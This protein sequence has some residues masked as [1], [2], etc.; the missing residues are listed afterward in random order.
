MA[1][2]LCYDKQAGE[3]HLLM[4]FIQENSVDLHCVGRVL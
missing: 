2:M 3:E 1:H 4:F